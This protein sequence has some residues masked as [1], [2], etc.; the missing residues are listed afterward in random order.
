MLQTTCV[1]LFSK[2]DW[3]LMLW[4]ALWAGIVAGAMFSWGRRYERK[5]AAKY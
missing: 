2:A 4:D 1:V 3:L 5:Q